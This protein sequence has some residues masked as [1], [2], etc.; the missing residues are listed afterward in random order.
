MV[1]ADGIVT[2][3]EMLQLYKLGKE[4]FGLTEK[5]INTLI[6]E[7]NQSMPSAESASQKIGMLYEMAQIAWSDNDL[8]NTEVELLETYARH[9][10]IVEDAVEP[11]I[12]FLL[13]CAQKG[14]SEE[15]VVKNFD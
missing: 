13:E 11:T 15:D 2:S 4:R 9:F 10:G 1:L 12:H 5:A 8:A 6:L 3:E 7:D 14:M